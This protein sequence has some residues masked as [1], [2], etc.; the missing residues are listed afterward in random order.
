[1]TLGRIAA[2]E[3]ELIAGAPRGA[4]GRMHRAPLPVWQHLRG[5]SGFLAPGLNKSSRRG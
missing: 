4:A 1:M 3:Q 5:S 2:A